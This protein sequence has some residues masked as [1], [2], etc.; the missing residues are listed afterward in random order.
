MLPLSRAP[1]C[2]SRHGRLRLL[3][4][5]AA[6]GAAVSVSL[7]AISPRPQ[8]P[9]SDKELLTMAI[10]A[11]VK[12]GLDAYRHEYGRL[13]DTSGI[14]GADI[15]RALNA[16]LRSRGDDERIVSE[17]PRRII[18]IGADLPV[19]DGLLCD[20]W[21]GS[22]HFDFGH[23]D[24]VSSTARAQVEIWSDGPMRNDCGKGDD[25]GLSTASRS[26]EAVQRGSDRD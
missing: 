9:Y 22:L 20:A 17:N 10:V 14:R 16:V 6:L 21:G 7:V 15:N 3:V 2:H 8:S 24:G 18:F 26:I 4:L 13:P 19:M 11:S 25:I 5:V 23:R 12:A 1:A